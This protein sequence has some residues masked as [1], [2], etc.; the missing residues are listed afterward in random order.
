MHNNRFLPLN[1]SVT[2]LRYL[3]Y[4]TV[5][6]NWACRLRYANIFGLNYV[7]SNFNCQPV[8]S[9]WPAQRLFV[10]PCSLQWYGRLCITILVNKGGNSY[11]E[12]NT[13]K[14]M[15]LECTSKRWTTV[16]ITN[17][18]RGKVPN[19]STANGKCT[20][21]ELSSCTSYDGGSGRRRS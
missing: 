13:A 8:A 10:F 18:C 19:L 3:Q 4:N 1:S 16:D 12:K 9:H 14:Y 7:W 5:Q 6:Y 11:D 17:C 2:N 20:L 21:P 15:W